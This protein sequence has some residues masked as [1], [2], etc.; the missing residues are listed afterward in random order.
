MCPQ[1]VTATKPDTAPSADDA[2]MREAIAP[3][4]AASPKVPHVVIE[5]RRGLSALGLQ[6]SWSYRDLLLTLAGRD[7]KLR[8]KQ[9]AL[10]VSW[11]VLQP[12]L[13]AGIFSV[14]FGTIAK[15]PSGDVPYFLFSF[16]GLLGWNAFNGTL[17]KASACVVENAGLVSKIFFPRLILPLSTVFS[18]LIDFG[19]SLCMM[20][21]LMICYGIAPTAAM[22]LIPVWLVLLVLLAVGLGLF[23]SAL[24]V[25]Y[26]DLRYVIPVLMQFLLYASPVAYSLSALREQGRV[27][28]KV[29]EWLYFNPLSGLLEAF[30]WSVLGRGHVNWGM[31]G[32][33]AVC[34][35]VVFVFGAY[36]FK[37]MER[38]FAD[39]I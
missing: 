25:P 28:P 33:S 39:V 2:A 29:L 6:E 16:A 21:V 38:K 18:T 13:A 11:V 9:T 34:V 36:S 31:V 3:A 8:Y 23:T 30:R 27:S 22:L 7:V 37:K 14:V 1:D 24:M 10:G 20:A 35:V 32:Y 17:T 12:L 19:V 5:P 26:R 4:G 15:L